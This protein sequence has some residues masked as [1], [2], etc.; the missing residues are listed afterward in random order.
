MNIAASK[1]RRSATGALVGSLIVVLGAPTYA[2][3]GQGP[4]RS[5]AT[6]PGLVVAQGKVALAEATGRSRGL[7]AP[8]FL[9]AWP[10]AEVLESQLV[11]ET[12]AMTL[13]DETVA[14]PAEGTFT[15]GIDEAETLEA[16]ASEAG[17]IDLVVV[18]PDGRGSAVTHTFPVK[19]D[20]VRSARAQVAKGNGRGVAALRSG[21]ALERGRAVADPSAPAAALADWSD[22]NYLEKL[23][24]ASTLKTNYGPR[25]VAVGEGYNPASGVKHTVTY[26]VGSSTTLGV[27]TSSSGAFGT[28]KAEGTTSRSSDTVTTFPVGGAGIKRQYKTYWVYGRYFVSCSTGVP[29]G[30]FSYYEVRPISFAGGATYTNIT[31]SPSATYCRPYANGSALQKTSTSAVTWSNGANLAPVIGIDLSSKSGYSSS[32]SVKYEF[33]ASRQLCGRDDYPGGTPI[34]LVAK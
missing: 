14:D 10:P 21:I 34:R 13:L 30:T 16:F 11:G 4:E 5:G 8:V 12:V 18:T 28:F 2:Y 6:P 33:S 7:G 31:T 25:L 17:D 15:L 3:A 24:C 19:L 27:A 1:A 20:E 32:V 23:G 9:Y 22:Q 26:T 29:G